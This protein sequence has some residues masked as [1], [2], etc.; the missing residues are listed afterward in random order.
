MTF[1]LASDC[2]MTFQANEGAT[3]DSA[4]EAWR[5]AA[6]D[7]ASSDHGADEERQHVDVQLMKSLGEP[8]TFTT[9]DDVL[10]SVTAL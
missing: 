5:A 10:F 8:G 7:Y 3:F 6:L 9:H 1:A 2:T 4:H